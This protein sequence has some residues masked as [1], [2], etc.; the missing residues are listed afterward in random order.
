MFSER[1]MDAGGTRLRYIALFKPYDVLTQF[2][3]VDRR[4]TP[5]H[6]V[7]VPADTRPCDWSASRSGRSRWAT[8]YPDS[9]ATSPPTSARRSGCNTP[10]ARGFATR[11]CKLEYTGRGNATYRDLAEYGTTVECPCLK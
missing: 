7:P 1:D 3:D 8:S 2:T 4:A 5:K 9:G 11:V 6:L 10:L